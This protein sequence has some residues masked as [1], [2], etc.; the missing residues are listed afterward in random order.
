MYI[1]IHTHLYTCIFVSAMLMLCCKLGA[2]HVFLI[3]IWPLW[4]LRQCIL[5]MKTQIMYFY[6]NPHA[7]VW[8]AFWIFD[9]DGLSLHFC[10]SYVTL[11]IKKT[12]LSLFLSI[13][14]FLLFFCNLLKLRLISICLY[15]V[16]IS[17]SS[18]YAFI[19]CY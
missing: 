5:Y 18:V 2:I 17:S 11:C 9:C 12:A 6:Q 16:T 15:T 1:Y 7:I 8:S 4:F 3:N 14:S 10:R 19:M 13:L